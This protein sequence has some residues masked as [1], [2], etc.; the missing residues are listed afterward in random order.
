[1]ESL[2]L[3]CFYRTKND[4]RINKKKGVTGKANASVG[5]VPE[6]VEEEV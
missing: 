1:V 6:A 3:C 2:L 4:A 5:E